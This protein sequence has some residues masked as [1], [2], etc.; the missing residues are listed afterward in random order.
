MI[1]GGFFLPIKHT[2]IFL[3]S[4]KKK[5]T[6]HNSEKEKNNFRIC[7]IIHKFFHYFIVCDRCAVIFCTSNIQRFRWCEDAWMQI[8]NINIIGFGFYFSPCSWK[9]S[10]HTFRTECKL[11]PC[12][13][14]THSSC[15]C[16]AGSSN[17]KDITILNILLETL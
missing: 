14:S 1:G 17:E 15:N 11:L 16:L 5:R 8:I 4:T 10:G 2:D 3:V 9:P 12:K 13:K 6:H 7:S